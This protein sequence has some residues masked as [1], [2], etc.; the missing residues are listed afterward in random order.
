MEELK[1]LQI[2][3]HYYRF[4]CNFLLL[5]DWSKSNIRTKEAAK[6]YLTEK[7]RSN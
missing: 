1:K 6:N 2:K 4:T 5:V 3:L 7:F